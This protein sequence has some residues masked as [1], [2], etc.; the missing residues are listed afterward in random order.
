MP[1]SVFVEVVA[2]IRRRTGSQDLAYEV[3]K[4][5]LN[6]ENLSFVALDQKTA[7]AL[8]ELAIQTGVR[9]M[10]ALVIQ[11]AKEFD[12]ELITFDDE[13]MKRAESLFKNT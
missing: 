3:K 9:G 11:T 1:Y 10:D 4:T 12:C 5:L 8:A 6:I 2:A 13:M 7:E